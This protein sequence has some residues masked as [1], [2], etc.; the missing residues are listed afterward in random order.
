ML[1]KYIKINEKLIVSGQDGKTGMWYCK[2]LPADTT[3]E[4]DKLI[5]E[6]NKIYNK[7]NKKEK[8]FDIDVVATKKMKK[9]G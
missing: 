3:K 6:L 7:Y 2:E 9:T 4:M 5:G 1:D 8:T